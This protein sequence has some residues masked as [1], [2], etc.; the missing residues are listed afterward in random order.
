MSLEQQM[1]LSRQ[2]STPEKGKKGQKNGKKKSFT[3]RKEHGGC[4]VAA[5]CACSM[6]RDVFQPSQSDSFGIFQGPARGSLHTHSRF[7]NKP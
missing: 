4:P 5:P 2:S 7:V 1:Q 6:W 3:E